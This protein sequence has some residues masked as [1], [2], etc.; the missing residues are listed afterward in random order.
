MRT[1][2]TSG[3]ASLVEAMNRIISKGIVAEYKIIVPSV[4]VYLK[5]AKAVGSVA[6]AD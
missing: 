4:K 2:K 3:S 5:Y 1:K 6:V